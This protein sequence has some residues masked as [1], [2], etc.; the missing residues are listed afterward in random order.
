MLLVKAYSVSEGEE[1][2]RAGADLVF[3]DIFSPDFPEATGSRES[4]RL[5]AYLPRIMDD[6]EL[7][8]A[9]VLLGQKKPA[10][11]LTGN[12]GFLAWRAEFNVPVY[13]DYSMNTF[14]D[15]DTLFFRRYGATPILSPEL[16]IDEMREI[17]DKDVVV[18]CH[19]DIIL[20][21]TL[22]ALKEKRLIDE[23][24]SNFAVRREDS[25]WQV[26]NSRPYGLFNDILT[27]RAMGFGQFFIDK[28]DKGAYLT[29]LYRGILA[30]KPVDRKKRRGHTAGH[31]Y[32]P[33]R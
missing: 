24:G 19:G 14:N 15:L 27:L 12:L 20:V 11:I 13:T 28:Q 2:L 6:E 5:G 31:L 22:I 17:K 25:Y 26:L 8:R 4:S 7:S 1:S 30:G 21:N 29:E 3:Y 23:K 9:L 33:V 32:R 10:A 16:S 18:F